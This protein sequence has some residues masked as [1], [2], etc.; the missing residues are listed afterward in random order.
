MVGVVVAPAL[1]EIYVAVKRHGAYLNGKLIK[2]SGAKHIK[3]SIVLAELGYV[4]EPANRAM[5]GNCLQAIIAQGPHAIRMMGS[6]VLALCYV[7]CGRLD[8]LYTGVAG[9]GWKPWDY[10]AGALFVEEAGGVLSTL[11]GDYFHV[12][13]SSCI[14]AASQDL[15]NEVKQCIQKELKNRA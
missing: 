15:C 14:A 1:G 3:D 13:A 4:R 11:E 6:G 5:F 10:C 8:A 12:E 9:E 7:A 2:S